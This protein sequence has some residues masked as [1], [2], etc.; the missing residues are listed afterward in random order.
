M[1]IQNYS[2]LT[3]ENVTLDGQQ[4]AA[5]AN[6]YVLSNNNGSV[7]LIGTTSITAPTG[8]VAFDMYYWPSNGY[9]DGV[10]VTVNTTGTITGK[11]EYA[12]DNTSTDAAAAEKNVLNI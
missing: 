4:L 5:G 3:L 7:Q 9:T 11:I 2:N 1:L 10:K 12:K 6:S 8:G